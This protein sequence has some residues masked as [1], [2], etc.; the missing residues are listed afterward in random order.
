MEEKEKSKK[1]T[2]RH[3][4]AIL[5]EDCYLLAKVAAIKLQISMSELISKALTEYVNVH[6]QSAAQ[7][8]QSQ[9]KE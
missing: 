6:F 7:A 1:P 9:L 4:Q 3:V 8:A 5:N 2:S